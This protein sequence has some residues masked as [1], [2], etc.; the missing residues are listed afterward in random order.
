MNTTNGI[1]YFAHGQESG[2]WGT[3]IQ[4]LAEIAKEKGFQVE[5]PDYTH[6]PD[7]DHRVRQLIAQVHRGKGKLVLVGS[8]AGGYVS[9]VASASIE[10][11]G[12]FLL[13]P[14]VSLR[15]FGAQNPQPSARR[16]WIVQGWND[17]VVSPQSVIAFARQHKMQLHLLNGDHRLVDVLPEVGMLF[18]LFLRQIIGDE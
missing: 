1:V 12:L 4:Y 15:G 6:L 7:P 8:S 11:H 18:E 14:A 3:K 9:A 2:P 13:A 17:D 16:R 5:S 10:P